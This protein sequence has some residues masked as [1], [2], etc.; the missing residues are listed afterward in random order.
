MYKC[1]I[2]HTTQKN[3]SSFEPTIGKSTDLN[4]HEV[5]M[6]SAEHVKICTHLI[7]LKSSQLLSVVSSPLESITNSSTNFS[8]H[9]T[10]YHTLNKSCIF[11]RDINHNIIKMS[12]I[13]FKKFF[14]P[15][16]HILIM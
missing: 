12:I 11:G 10:C 5:C 7:R 9:H 8:C 4:V 1:K 14:R 3:K 6:S 16:L 13:S 2:E 15:K